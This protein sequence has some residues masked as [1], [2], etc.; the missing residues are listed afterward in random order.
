MSTINATSYIHNSSDQNK[1]VRVRELRALRGPRTD[2]A[3]LPDVTRH[4]WPEDKG[5]LVFEDLEL[6]S[7]PGH[8][9]WLHNHH[10]GELTERSP[11][12]YKNVGW[13]GPDQQM[14]WG[15]RSYN[16]GDLFVVDNDFT[17]IKRE[18]G[19]YMSTGG[20]SSFSGCTFLRVGSQGIQIVN[21]DVPYQQYGPD[22]LSPT[23]NATHLISDSHFLDC[24]YRG[25]RPSFNATYFDPGNEFYPSTIK[26]QDSSWVS[27]WPTPGLK[28]N[29]STGAFVITQYNP[30]DSEVNPVGSVV[31][32]N[33]LF[34]FTNGD[35]A[36]G[37][38][39]GANTIMLED[40]TFIAR[41]HSQPFI[42]VNKKSNYTTEHIFIKNCRARNVK[43]RVWKDGEVLSQ[44]DLECP[45]GGLYI[46]GNTGA[47]RRMR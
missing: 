38:I 46:N 20:S 31:I 41:A 24:G 9:Q 28:G 17:E 37:S 39:R 13:T 7:E 14:K 16:P 44:V 8:R 43:L 21:R 23:K 42:D 18:H 45:D 12:L 47:V 30:G 22:N 29:Y 6:Q 2:L 25:D 33:C 40:S 10:R 32:Q 19:M 15:L 3:Y 11:V 5:R 4:D 35:R 36:I 1:T 27:E 26:F 34:D